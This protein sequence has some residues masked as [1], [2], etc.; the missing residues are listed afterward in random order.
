MNKNRQ[1]LGLSFLTALMLVALFSGFFTILANPGDFTPPDLLVKK[2][3]AADTTGTQDAISGLEATQGTAQLPKTEL[4]KTIGN[5]I[6]AA[7]SLIGVIF[8]AL[9]VYGGILWM[10][11]RGNEDQVTKAKNI[12]TMAIIGVAIVLAAYG[13]TFFIISSLK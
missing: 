3:L 1:L 11:A 12:I 6:G 13:I 4:S 8:L 5:V 7:L 2:A 9:M 10:T